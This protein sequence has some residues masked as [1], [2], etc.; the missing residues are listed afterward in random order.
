MAVFE[1]PLILLFSHI[2]SE[3]TSLLPQLASTVVFFQHSAW[4][5]GI[6]CF[7]FIREV[8]LSALDS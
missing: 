4:L 8:I 2:M 5:K 3:K 6:L 1:T 7:S